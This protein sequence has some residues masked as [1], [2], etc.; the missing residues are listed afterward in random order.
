MDGFDDENLF[1]LL[2]KIGILSCVSTLVSNSP[3]GCATPQVTSLKSK[4]VN[5]HKQANKQ[6]S[7][8]ASKYSR[9]STYIHTHDTYRPLT[10]NHSIQLH[11]SIPKA[12]SK[13]KAN[14]TDEQTERQADRETDDGQPDWHIGACKGYCLQSPRVRRVHRY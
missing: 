13:S 8:Q 7:E 5:K 11:T 12:A 10:N 9:L 4:Q 2:R 1:V 3:P 6:A 14:A